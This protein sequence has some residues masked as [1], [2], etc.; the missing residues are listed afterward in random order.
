MGMSRSA[1][2]I[3]G[4]AA[5]MVAILAG[6]WFLL[7]APKFESAAET[8]SE[9]ESTRSTNDILEIQ[10]NQL[11]ADAEHIDQYKEQLAAIAIQ[12][13]PVADLDP[14]YDTVE[15]LAAQTSVFLVSIA[16]GSPISVAEA[17]AAVMPTATDTGATDTGATDNATASPGDGAVDTAEETA[18]DAEAA[19][20]AQDDTTATA[21]P[22]PLAALPAQL[23]GFVA[24]PVVL[25][26]VGTYPAVTSFI[27]SLQNVPERLFLV[28]LI[29]ATRQKQAAAGQGR[30]IV[31]DGFI[32]LIVGGY[33]YVLED[34][35]ALAAIVARDAPQ[36]GQP[37]EPVMPSSGANPWVPFVPTNTGRD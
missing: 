9:A 15:L 35:P 30:P 20:D 1:G 6:T 34:D 12:M 31:E 23:E 29:D 28:T 24:V 32:E 11:R 7:A 5:L 25:D 21:E 37:V 22:T 33:L 8:R 3:A 18:D 36:S 2:W 14:F 27:D 10:A 17:V 4:A 13:P 16:P 26:V 19:A